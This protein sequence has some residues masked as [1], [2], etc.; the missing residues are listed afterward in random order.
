M[1]ECTK[2][3][4]EKPLTEY[5]KRGNGLGADGFKSHCKSCIRKAKKIFRDNN[6][7]HMSKMK[8]ASYRRHRESTIKKVVEYE[9][10]RCES[11]PDFKLM[12]GLR[13]R[14]RTALN[15]KLRVANT[16][17]VLGC[18]YKHA[19][20]HIESLFTE[21]MTWGQLGLL[22]DGTWITLYHALVLI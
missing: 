12:K 22:M 7:D 4:K 15:G 2:C 3:K 5:Y 16:R 21:G 13:S 10:N 8:A 20:Q 17:E 11:D 9:R 14:Q 6:K 19:R 1:K 18:S